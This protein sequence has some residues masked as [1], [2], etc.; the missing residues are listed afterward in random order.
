[1]EINTDPMTRKEILQSYEV[2][3]HGTITSPGK[4]EAEPIYAPYFYSMDDCDEELVDDNNDT[5]FVYYV[6]TYDRLEF[7]E[8]SE[9]DAFV[10][11]TESDQ[12]FVSCRAF[13]NDEMVQYHAAFINDL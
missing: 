3:E 7:P 11:L 6:K 9:N 2:N 8:L 10:V 4:F 13:S 5:A 1:M 12:G